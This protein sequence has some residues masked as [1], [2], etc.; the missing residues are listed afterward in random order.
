MFYYFYCATPC[1]V[2]V[3][4]EYVGIANE[5]LSYVDA[6]NP[7]FEFIPINANFLPVVKYVEETSTSDNFVQIIDLYGGFLLIPNFSKRIDGEYKSIGRKT[8]DLTFPTFVS[9]YSQCGI[10]LCIEREGK[11]HT[12]SIPFTPEDIRFE[13]ARYEDKE[14]IV[15]ICIGKKSLILGFSLLGDIKLVLKSL[16]DGYGFEKK[17]LSM[18]ENKNDILKHAVSSVWEFTDEVKLVN[19]SVTRKKQAFTL[20]ENLF[21]YA[22]FEEL[23]LSGDCSDFLT[24]RLK[25]KI[26]DLKTFLGNFIKVLPPPHFKP[27][28]YLTLLYKNKVEYVVLNYQNG[29]IDNI[30][31]ID[32]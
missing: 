1:A 23:L 30:S 10:K 12:E 15:I 27:D 19:Y 3:N 13:T 11:I 4:G 7:F 20:N 8:F 24:P 22:F 17:R 21:P 5:N 6:I 32:K 25:P 18:L 26:G 28:N 16:C 31:I 2:K 29:L 14:Y 9:C